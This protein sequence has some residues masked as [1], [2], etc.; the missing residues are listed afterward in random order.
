MEKQA[1]YKAGFNRLPA[2]AYW[3][4]SGGTDQ[5]AIASFEAHFKTM[6]TELVMI[7]QDNHYVYF[8]P[9]PK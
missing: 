3:A 5:Q 7:P 9:V 1:E 2:T 8:M 6:P 4:L